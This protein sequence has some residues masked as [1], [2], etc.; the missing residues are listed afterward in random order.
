MKLGI[1]YDLREDYGIERDSHVFADFCHPDE[2]GYMAEAVRRLGY[3]PVKLGNMYQLNERIKSG[4]FDCDLVLVCDEGIKSRNREA[5]VPALLELNHIPYIGSDAYCMGLSQNK[6]HTKLVAKNL[7]IDCPDGIYFPYCEGWDADSN[8]ER[9]MIS[10]VIARLGESGLKYPLVVKPNEEGYSM[11]VFLVKDDEELKQAITFNFDNY[12]EAVLIEEY[13]RGKELYA[14]MIGSDDRAYVLG[15]GICRY[16]DGSDI[17][18]F[19]LDDK[20]FKV[21]RDEIPDL[22]RDTEKKIKDNSLLLYRHMGCRDFGRCDYKLTEDGRVVLIEMNPRPGLTEG[23][24]YEN[25]ARAVGKTYDEVLG[26]IIDS[27]RER[28]QLM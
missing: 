23:G 2:I 20:C 4:T 5:I 12:K 14:P 22:G 25:C 19:S 13:I 28:Y 7:G 24:P 6:Y 21:I 15:I 3:N 1:T 11:G 18:I 16:E 8:M 26:E 9:K 10:E 17:D 27:A